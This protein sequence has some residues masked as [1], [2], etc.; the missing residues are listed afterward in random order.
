M[1]SSMEKRVRRSTAPIY[2]VGVVW[3][4][5][6]VSSSHSMGMGDALLAAALSAVVFVVGKA[7]FP[8]KSYAVPAGQAAKETEKKE[9]KKPEPP[10][11]PEVQKL[12][13]ERER[14]LC[15]NA[16]LL[17]RALEKAPGKP[18]FHSGQEVLAGL[19]VEE[20][21]ALAR[22]WSQFDREENPGLSLTEEELEHAKKTPV[23]PGGAPA[24]AGAEAVRRTAHGGAG[25]ADA[26]QRLSLVSGE[27]PSG[28]GGGAGAPVSR[29]SGGGPGRALPG[30]RPTGA[31][32]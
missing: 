30:V 12:L 20:I 14:A 28:P 23:R 4:V 6:A 9:E 8:D 16:C 15:S 3:L 1:E 2:L 31:G 24:L 17:A 19:T 18:L 26:G 13:Q 10:K 32:E 27:R 25:K 11:D 22:R 5:L 7:V 21:S 29:L